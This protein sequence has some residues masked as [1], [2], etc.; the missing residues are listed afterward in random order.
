MFTLYFTCPKCEKD[1]TI[2]GYW[3]WIWQAPFHGWTTRYTRCPCCGRRSRMK[4]H[5]ITR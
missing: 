5:T 2:K 4:W 3:R 1:F